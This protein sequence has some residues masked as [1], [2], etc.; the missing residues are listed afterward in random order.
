MRPLRIAIEGLRSF[1]SEVVIDFDDRA[2]I[3]II[4]DT[5]AGK[6]SILEA[7]TYAL[8]GQST[9]GSRAKQE[10]MHDTSEIMRV[11][12]RFRV[13]NEEWEVARVDRRAA[14]GKLRPPAARLVRYGPDGATLEMVEQARKVNGRIQGL[15]GLDSEAF[16][17]TVV[18]PQGQFARLLVEDKPSARTEILRQVWRTGEL[19]AAAE[20]VGL[21][22]DE[23][24]ILRARVE[25]AAWQYPEDP[26]ARLDELSTAAQAAASVAEAA[27]QLRDRATRANDALLR[28]ET[29]IKAAARAMAGI[30]RDALGA[31]ET[32]LRP[33]RAAQ[34]RIDAEQEK[35]EGEEAGLRR[36]LEGIPDDD[37]PDH[38]AV[39]QALATLAGIPGRLESL[40]Q[41]WERVRRGRGGIK[42][43]LK[44]VEDLGGTAEEAAER[45]TGHDALAP[46][47]V[48]AVRVASDRLTRAQRW[49]EKCRDAHA[50]V[51]SSQEVLNRRQGEIGPIISQ[52]ATAQGVCRKADRKAAR[53]DAAFAAAQRE[54]A[55]A[56]A[57]HGLCAG[58]ECPVCRSDL[59]AE[60]TALPNRDLDD[61]RDLLEQ[62]KSRAANAH[63]DLTRLR[64]R[65]ETVVQRVVDATAAVEAHS[66]DLEAATDQLVQVAGPNAL[67]IDED[68]PFPDRSRLLAS[69][70]RDLEDAQEQRERH[71]QRAAELER[72]RQAVALR[73]RERQVELTAA[74]AEAAR[75]TEAAAS[76]LEDVRDGVGAV[77]HAFRPRMPLPGDADGSHRADVS[78]FLDAAP[79][80]RAVNLARER[81]EVL[82]AR[83]AKRR[84]LLSDLEGV[85]NGLRLLDEQRQV[86]VAKPLQDAARALERCRTAALE[87][88]RRLADVSQLAAGGFEMPGAY[89][90]P[91]GIAEL[92]A[93][94]RTVSAMRT[95]V[96]AQAELVRAEARTVANAARQELGRVAERLDQ[97]PDATLGEAVVALARSVAEEARYRARV[98]ERERDGFAA[99]L[100]DVLD[101]RSV[102]SKV[103]A[104][105]LA[106]GD[107]NAALKPGAF[108]KW[109]TLRRSRNLLVY[110]SRMLDEMTGGRYAFADPGDLDHQQWQVVDND[111]GQARSPASLSG[112]EQFIGSLA[113]ALGMVEMMARSGGRL[114]SLFLDEGFGSLDRGNLDAAIE[115]LT[116]VAGRGRM[117]GVISHVSAVAEQIDDVLAVTRPSTGSQATWLSRAERQELARADIGSEGAAAL[118]GLLD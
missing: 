62:A 6:S 26:K 106:L 3:A 43:T 70:E 11:V 101:L 73:L 117:V 114:E 112:G 103:E 34:R 12:L 17:R 79:V 109:L 91:I 30:E 118:A 38:H 29:E 68:E 37:G 24:R 75:A 81:Q 113:L 19:E 102:A 5:G 92:E 80:D 54:D 86:E 72:A 98:R 71:R 13:A 1:R 110:A 100:D 10:L 41:A 8:Y 60:W 84:L 58:D 104:L 42:H 32:R 78:T 50:R 23:V 115:A 45:L 16:L 47:L 15:V 20:A 108:L 31:L 99:I 44:L 25:Q 69:L 96:L 74:R 36:K 63:G 89:L 85:R 57:S 82:R 53:A 4:G 35:L 39:A 77:P 116:A 65:Q 14:G 33:V 87:A 83:E 93:G 27:A 51:Q 49:L 88:V 94:I 90:Y 40:G 61:A 111:S 64:A 76:A 18:L 55:A 66:S 46:P 97:D 105:E 95:E 56:T 67:T 21:K 22:L 107:L 2:L 48:E 7:M 52:V 59:P 9:R 28:S